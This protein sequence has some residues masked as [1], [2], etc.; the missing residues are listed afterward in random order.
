MV[1]KKKSSAKKASPQ[2]ASTKKAPAKKA[3]KK[4]AK[5]IGIKK[6][7]KKLCGGWKA[8]QDSMPPGPSTIHV[9]GTCIFPRRGY[10]ASLK[11]AEPQG[12]NPAIL[13]LRLTI[14]KPTGPGIQIPQTVQIRYKAK[15][16]RMYTHVTILPDGGTIKVEQ[17]I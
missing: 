1:A 11:P 17:V 3:A 9:T 7:I 13:M 12:I 4:A 14:T 15:A 8:W 10:K 5:P 2:K 6:P 16:A